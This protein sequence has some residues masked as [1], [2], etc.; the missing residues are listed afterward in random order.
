[1]SS[2]FVLTVI[3]SRD[4]ATVT[5]E[6]EPMAAATEL[7]AAHAMNQGDAWAW[8]QKISKY[9]GDIATGSISANIA[10]QNATTSASGL[11]TATANP[12]N[13]DTVTINGTVITLVT[14]TPTG[15][16]VK[17]GSTVQETL[18]NLVAF[19]NK[20]GNA[21]AFAGIVTAVVTSPLSI[22]VLAA[23][24]G[25]AGNS[26]TTV[27]GSTALN[28]AAATLL[29]GVAVTTQHVISAGL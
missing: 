3:D 20:G 22:T 6:T 19:I 18:Q 21:G 14:G 26:I 11:L 9:F 12:A 8:C 1:M 15:S 27:E 16:Q 10:I 2:Q 17:I 7:N 25:T 24:P 29:G 13:A 23:V 28:F 4:S 5:S